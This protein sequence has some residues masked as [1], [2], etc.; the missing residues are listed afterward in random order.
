MS[1]LSSSTSSIAGSVAASKHSFALLRLSDCRFSAFFSRAFFVRAAGV[2]APPPA[3]RCR[4]GFGA[5]SLGLVQGARR[6]SR[7]VPVG[8]GRNWKRTSRKVSA[9]ETKQFCLAP[10][11]KG[12]RIGSRVV[13]HHLLQ[14]KAEER[15]RDGF[16]ALL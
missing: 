5:L 10:L 15:W 6:P 12:R 14:R 1:A 9:K 11:G 3:L 16:V 2:L 7:F 13:G 4:H 8:Q